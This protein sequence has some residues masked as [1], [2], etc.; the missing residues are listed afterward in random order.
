[1]KKVRICPICN[2][3]YRQGKMY[4]VGLEKEIEIVPGFYQNT[5]AR[6]VF[7]CP[8]CNK[9]AGYKGRREKNG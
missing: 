3:P 4:K 6:V 8:E 7:I 1:M 5:P 9:I 2:K